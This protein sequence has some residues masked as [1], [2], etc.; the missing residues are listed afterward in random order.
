MSKKIVHIITTVEL[1]GAEKQLLILC[2]EQVLLGNIVKVVF[3]KG[4]P[5]LAPDFAE[6]GVE[7]IDFSSEALINQII[8]L[9]RFF[10]EF[11]PNVVHGHLPRAELLTMLSRPKNGFFV[12]RHNAEKFWPGAPNH[13][14][15][16]LSRLVI[17]NSVSCIAISEAVLKFGKESGEFPNSAKVKLIHYG[18][19]TKGTIIRRH[20]LNRQINLL[21]IARLEPQKDLPTLLRAVQLL[22][23]R[24]LTVH[25]HI[26]G[27]GSLRIFLEQLCG[28]LEVTPV[29]TFHGKVK[30]VDSFYAKADLFVLP[31][32]YEGFGL[33]Y[34]EALANGVPVI[35]SR[36]FAALEIFGEKY[37]GLFNIGDFHEL[38][39]LIA[40]MILEG[41]PAKLADHYEIILE[42]FSS[43]HMATALDNVYEVSL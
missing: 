15:K 6:I 12:T 31:S 28:Q 43:E 36:N 10:K 9:R 16:A 21:C 38:A 7:A 8:R 17:R 34:L 14:S 2:A 5:S 30:D 32:L 29:V 23:S 26:L 27:E 3:L 4:N 1:G 25:L 11:N 18:I 37:V 42:N 35:T 40:R 33:V 20:S 39:N 41:V 19:K 24:G 13:I 22:K